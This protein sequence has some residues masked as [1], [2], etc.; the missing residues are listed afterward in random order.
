MKKSLLSFIRASMILA[1]LIVIATPLTYAGQGKIK[2]ARRNAKQQEAKLAHH[3]PS[4][5]LQITQATDV[6]NKFAKQEAHTV[7]QLI[8]TVGKIKKILRGCNLTQE[9]VNAIFSTQLKELTHINIQ[10][11]DDKTDEELTPQEDFTLDLYTA[12]LGAKKGVKAYLDE[13]NTTPSIF[14]K[15]L[16]AAAQVTLSTSLGRAMGSGLTGLSDYFQT[17]PE[18]FTEYCG[19]VSLYAYTAW[20]VYNN[21]E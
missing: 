8:G 6:W 21:R 18:Q 1:A 7:K 4:E 16:E 14:T 12:V 2:A 20:Y 13:Y 19:L 10:K 5:R 11:F 3:L 9:E 17:T 15:A